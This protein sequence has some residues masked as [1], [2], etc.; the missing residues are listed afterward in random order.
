MS[1]NPYCEV[2][3]F[4]QGVYLVFMN[5]GITIGITA[6]CH[7]YVTSWILNLYGEQIPEDIL[8][9]PSILQQFEERQQIHEDIN[10]IESS[11]QSEQ[12]S[13]KEDKKP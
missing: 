9:D 5:F 7:K 12:V 2:K 4:N 10:E 11:E 6:F 13:E 8:V 1:F 3:K